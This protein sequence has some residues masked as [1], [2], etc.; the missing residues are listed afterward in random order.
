[1]KRAIATTLFSLSLFACDAKQLC[2]D[3]GGVYQPWFGSFACNYGA[4]EMP[5]GFCLIPPPPAE[6]P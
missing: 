2:E 4:C 1:M 3:Q 5:K 6:K